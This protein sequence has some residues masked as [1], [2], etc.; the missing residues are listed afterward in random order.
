MAL[1][2]AIVPHGGW[3][4]ALAEVYI[5]ESGSHGGSSVLCL[6][7]YVFKKREAREFT[8]EWGARLKHENLPYWHT[9]PAMQGHGKPPFVPEAD[10]PD[11]RRDKLQRALIKRVREQ[12]AYGFSI[13]VNEAEY[14]SIVP[15]HPDLGSPYSFCLRMCLVAA[16]SWFKRTDFDGR[17]AYFFEAGHASQGEA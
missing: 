13:T 7:G 6:A 8:R 16:Y 2:D 4:V 15:S 3:L 14:R 12:T 11:E 10:W 9:N 5:D 1:I 17:V